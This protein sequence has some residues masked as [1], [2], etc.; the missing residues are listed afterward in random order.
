MT[1]Q[2]QSTAGHATNDSDG[3]LALGVQLSSLGRHAEALDAYR[4][5][6]ELDPA[7]VRLYNHF[8]NALQR[9]GQ[10]EGAAEVYEMALAL[11][12]D[13]GLHNNLGVALKKLGRLVEA[14]EHL[15]RALSLDPEH[16]D[17]RSNLGNVLKL[18]GDPA[19]AI[20]QY[21]RILERRPNHAPTYSNVGNACQAL[22]NLD[23]AGEMYETALALDPELAEAH[24]NRALLWLQQGQFERGWKEY[25]WGVATGDRP[26]RSMPCPRWDG[27]ALQGRR[28]LIYAEQG[29]GDSVQFVRLFPVLRKQGAYV[30]FECP[31]PLLNLIRDSGLADEVIASGEPLPEADTFAS[32]LDLPAL[33]NLTLDTLPARQS[34]LTVDL[35]RRQRWQD[36]L[37]DDCNL[38]VG[39]CWAGGP[40]YLA[41]AQRSFDLADLAPLGAV[42][43]VRFFNLQRGAAAEQAAAPPAGLHL[44]PLETEWDEFADMAAA[45]ANLDL[46]ITVDTSVAHLAGALGV[47][48]WTLLAHVPDWR[49]LLERDDSPWYPS[50]RLFRQRRAGDWGELVQRVHAELAALVAHRSERASGSASDI[51]AD[52]G[53]PDRDQAMLQQGMELHGAG[54]IKGATLCYEQVLAAQPDNPDALRLLGVI[55]QGQGDLDRAAQLMERALAEEPDS[56]LLYTSLGHVYKDGRAAGLALQCYRTA[57]AIDPRFADA[58]L[59]TGVACQ[60]DGELD[61]A[62]RAY[63]QLLELDPAHRRGLFNFAVALRAAGQEAEAAEGF[64]RLLA[65]APEHVEARVQL[66]QLLLERGQSD[67][68][69]G[70][71]AEALRADDRCFEAHRLMGNLHKDQGRYQRAIESY[72][73]ALSL[74]PDAM[75]VHNNLGNTYRAM[76]E[77]E[78]AER[79]YRKAV[80]LRPDVPEGYNNLGTLYKD[81]GHLAEA[82]KWFEQALEVAPDFHFALGNLVKVYQEICAWSRYGD[83]VERLIGVTAELLAQGKRV[84]MPPFFSLSLPVGAD[85]QQQV[86]R[87]YVQTVVLPGLVKTELAPEPKPDAR[88]RLR[89][90]Y[91]SSDFHTHATAQ[92]MLSLFGLHDRE[93]FEIF[94]YSLGKD[95]GSDYRKRIITDC[96]HFID[97]RDWHYTDIARRIAEDGIHIL[98]DLKGYTM[99]IRPEIFALRPAPLQVSYLGFPGTM[100]ASFID[101]IVTDETVTPAADQQYYDEQFVY[102]PHSY[103]VNDHRQRIAERTPSRSECGLPEHGFVFCCFNNNYKIEPEV[104]DVWMRILQHVPGSVLWL[105]RASP[106][107]EANLRVEA[108]QRG[109]EPDRLVFAERRPKAEHLARHRLADLFLDTFYYNAHTTASDALWAGVPVLTCA[110]ETFASRVGASLL[111]AVGLSELIADSRAAYEQMAITLATDHQALAA[112]RARLQQDLG[113]KPL[114]DTERFARNLERAYQEM[115]RRHAAGEAPS[116]I[117]VNEPEGASMPVPAATL[118]QDTYNELLIGCGSRHE[119]DIY[120]N[121][122]KQWTNLVTLDI[123]AD[124]RPDV[125]WDLTRVP[126]P[127]EDDTFDEIHAYEVLEHVGTQGD[128]RFFFAQFSDFWRILK[129]GGVLI[130]TVPLPTSVWAWGDPSHT[131]VIPK[132]SFIFLDQTQY[133]AQIGK[134]PMS[135]FRYLYKADFHRLRVTEAGE[136]LA[137]VLQAVKPSRISI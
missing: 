8:A 40:A 18:A 99:D 53:D 48:V 23:A 106:E 112:L 64:E 35:T 78:Q 113:S 75:G 67:Q 124:H 105:L 134:T 101:Y 46:V 100:G 61:A 71:L 55:A 129:P 80:E 56:A 43:G 82:R 114:F 63:R 41:N 30:V 12:P 39:L 72:G 5:A 60:L 9:C 34:Y 51:R 4:R 131:R 122:R 128:Y 52:V 116:S 31:K 74:R 135:D 28:I 44:E 22:G 57:L 123:N 19:A 47:P 26:Q 136:K 37:R 58:W 87:N 42:P 119:K 68:A 76:G 11:G 77:P 102:L 49:W 10:F 62:I 17:A 50:M 137:F 73:R 110:G 98:V 79:C 130:G 85:L 93:G 65:S 127:F 69:A 120:V 29:F 86:A 16:L 111:R 21:R 27:S 132:E 91:V 109:I 121:E 118:R 95:D 45:M 14:Q 81:A 94:A 3:W 54:D 70:H 89:I 96:D 83:T 90:G 66:A 133:T 59:G 38:R 32:L 88:G 6:L 1:E 92:L 7:D 126:L 15:Q 33:L 24:W 13:A 125:I 97:V 25:G 20:D 108:Q 117:T 2:T 104:F 103:Q 115:W 84:P 107:S 36:A